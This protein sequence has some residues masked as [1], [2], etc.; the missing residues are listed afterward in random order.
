MLP[1]PSYAVFLFARPSPDR[2]AALSRDERRRRCA[3]AFPATEEGP[4]GWIISRG[5]R[6]SEEERLA[7]GE[8]WIQVLEFGSLSG[9]PND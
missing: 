7:P 6:P 3:P 2:L 9:P 8:G 1:L 5:E 4:K